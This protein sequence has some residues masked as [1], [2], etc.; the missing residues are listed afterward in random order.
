M[1]FLR[2]VRRTTLALPG[3]MPTWSAFLPK[4]TASI[5]LRWWMNW[6]SKWQRL[7]VSS[8]LELRNWWSESLTLPMFFHRTEPLGSWSPS[9]QP[10][11]TPHEHVLLLHFYI[12]NS[13]HVQT[14]RKRNKPHYTSDMLEFC[15]ATCCVCWRYVGVCSKFAE[16]LCVL[17]LEKED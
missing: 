10:A 15:G 13:D 9:S 6:N 1:S 12:S 17:W 7:K 14:S 8:L 11:Y 2:L 5:S 16:P 3:I 4:A